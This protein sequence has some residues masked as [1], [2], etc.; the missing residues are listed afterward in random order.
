MNHR[1]HVALFLQRMT[2]YYISFL[3]K[4]RT[5]NKHKVQDLRDNENNVFF[6]K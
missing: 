1:T 2:L 5:T 6:C 3:I 4:Q